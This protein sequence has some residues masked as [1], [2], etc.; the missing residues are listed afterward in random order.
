ML[1]ACQGYFGGRFDL[2]GQRVLE[3][4]M[5]LPSLF[6]IVILSSLVTPLLELIIS[7]VAFYMAR[8]GWSGQSRVFERE[9]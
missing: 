6:I 8:P 4:S 5:G 9:I 7:N 2:Y 3:V 1:G